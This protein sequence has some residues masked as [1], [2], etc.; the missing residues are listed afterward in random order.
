MKSIIER[1]K[2]RRHRSVLVVVRNLGT[3]TLATVYPAYLWHISAPTILTTSSGSKRSPLTLP[4]IEWCRMR[5]RIATMRTPSPG[6]PCCVQRASGSP[7]STAAKKR[8]EASCQ[9]G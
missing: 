2:R 4:M 8:A 7:P 3:K 1:A 6:L 9:V 5:S